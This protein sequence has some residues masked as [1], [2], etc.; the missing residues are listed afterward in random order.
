MNH[1]LCRDCRFYAPDE[2]PYPNREMDHRNGYGQGTCRR[3]APVAQPPD[4]DDH[5]VNYGYWPVVMSGDF[6]GE[7]QESTTSSTSRPP[8]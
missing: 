8:P 3:H 1:L 7:F 6:C 5:V 4:E 2:E